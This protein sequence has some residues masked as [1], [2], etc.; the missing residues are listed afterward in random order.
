MTG[1]SSPRRNW[2]TK[3]SANSSDDVHVT[4]LV[5]DTVYVPDLDAE[6]GLSIL[7]EKGPTKVLL[8][9]GQAIVGRAGGPLLLAHCGHACDVL[10]V[11]HRSRNAETR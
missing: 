8:D 3:V 9:T 10:R 1:Y 7:V 6:H 5:E 11:R 4:C 2:S